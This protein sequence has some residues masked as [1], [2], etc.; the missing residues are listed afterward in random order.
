MKDV[1]R[2]AKQ[3]SGEQF[4]MISGVHLMLL[5]FVDNLASQLLELL[6]IHEHS[7]ELAQEISSWMM[8]SALVL[9]LLSLTAKQ[10]PPTIVC[11]QRMQ[12]LP[13]MQL[14]INNTIIIFKV[15]ILSYTCFATQYSVI[16]EILDWL[17]ALIAMRGVLKSASMRHG[18]QSV[19]MPGMP[20]M[21]VSLVDSWDT[22]DLVC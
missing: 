3:M 7:L 9:R 22:Q 6:P 4:V 19:T 12:E 16:L 10:A 18:A 17:V 20:W 11:I 5:L 14:V 2:Y 1:W 15:I 13:A 8:F 21:P